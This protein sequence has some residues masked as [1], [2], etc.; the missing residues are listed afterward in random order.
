MRRWFYFLLGLLMLQALCSQAYAVA[1]SRAKLQA[2]LN[3]GEQAQVGHEMRRA[4]MSY[5]KAVEE[6]AKFGSRSPEMQE[7]EARLAAVYVLQGRL[8]EAAPHYQKARDIALE[9][10][11]DGHEAPESFVWLD[12][13]ADAY[14]LQ[15]ASQE[16]DYCYSRCIELRKAISPRHKRLAQIEAQYGAYLLSKGKVAQGDKFLKEGHAL[17]VQLHGAESKNAGHSSLIMANAYY[18]V[19]KFNEAEKCSADAVAIIQKQMGNSNEVLANVRRLHAVALTKLGR[20]KEAEKEVT[21]A[22]AIHKSINGVESVE[23][24]YDLSSLAT[25]YMASHNL[26]D[27]ESTV[28]KALAIYKKQPNAIREKRIDTLRLGAKL[29]RLQ[30]HNAAAAKLEAEVNELLKH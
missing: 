12:D 7:C 5:L 19:G 4:E 2:L 3:I 6:A 30:H 23:Y 28:I 24:A 21:A 11:K 25:I 22:M 10:K 17:D 1:P 14:E 8:T 16:Q 13:L 9:L 15:A 29:A 27:A 26:K 18:S 20:F